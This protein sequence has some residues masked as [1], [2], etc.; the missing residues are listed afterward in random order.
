M[1]LA[2]ALE[3]AASALPAHADAIRPANGD[4]H[5]LL[6]GLDAAAAL[7]VATWLLEQQPAAAEDLLDAWSAEEAGLAHLRALAARDLGRSGRKALRRVLHRL[8]SRGVRVDEAPAPRAPRR[9]PEA[10]EPL[11]GALLSDLDPLGFR[12]GYLVEPHEGGGARI[13]ELLLDEAAGVV[14]CRVYQAPRGR[15]RRF[16]REAGRGTGPRL[17][18]VPE[19]AWRALVRRA[20]AAQP[21]DRPPPRSFAEWRSRLLRAA[22]AA[23]TPGEVLAGRLQVPAEPARVR[24]VA[25]R[26]REG[27]LGPWP[28]PRDRLRE[29]EERIRAAM[30]SGLVLSGSQ[31]GERLR[32]LVREAAERLFAEEGG[33]LLARR[34]GEAA[35]M[36]EARGEEELAR[37]LLSAASA[38]E[39]EPETA[40]P[41][42][43]AF[44]EAALAPVL[45]DLRPPEGEPETSGDEGRV[46]RP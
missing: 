10:E 1:S 21:A 31:R 43:E 35:A 29:E 27:G 6:A 3:E 39:R 7:E 13:F 11:S 18:P 5:R 19:D 37:D 8:R 34:L 2:Q 4:P 22:E 23:Q 30:A 26:V 28:P 46:L 44:A 41:L 45:R 20:V 9:L 12:I 36:A 17:V 33:R 32:D 16:L 24:R 40:A 42:T 38:V 14:D 25:E 15:A